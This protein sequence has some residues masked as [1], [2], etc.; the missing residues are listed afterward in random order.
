MGYERERF[1]ERKWR[2][3]VS[4]KSLGGTLQKNKNKKV[5]SFV[6]KKHKISLGCYDSD[7]I[8]MVREGTFASRSEDLCVCFIRIYGP[9][10]LTQ[11]IT[12]VNFV[13]RIR[14]LSLGSI[15]FILHAICG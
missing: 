9:F 5:F 13:V 7:F 4:M 3:W 12:F 14:S 2:A 6:G 1:S 10:G 15:I 11:I 8:G